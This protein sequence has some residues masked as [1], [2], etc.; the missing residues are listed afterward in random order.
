MDGTDADKALVHGAVQVLIDW[1]KTADPSAPLGGVMVARINEV[2]A[3]MYE[4]S[5]DE[6]VVCLDDQNNFLVKRLQ[7]VNLVAADCQVQ[8]VSEGR[9]LQ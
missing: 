1:A 5:A 8:G 6:A 7:I 2:Q 3:L 9:T 4:P